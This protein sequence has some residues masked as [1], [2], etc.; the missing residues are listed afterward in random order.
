[1]F[2]HV[3]RR[4]STI[5]QAPVAVGEAVLLYPSHKPT[6]DISRDVHKNSR[7]S[8]RESDKIIRRISPYNYC[9]T[10]LNGKL[11]KIESDPEVCRILP[12]VVIRKCLS[13][14]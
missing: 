7:A 2:Y 11:A 9:N 14:V 3:L 5:S 8:I 1:M 4:D 10:T 12:V 13:L 6:D